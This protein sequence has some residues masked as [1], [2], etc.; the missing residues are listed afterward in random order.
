MMSKWLEAFRIG[1][2]IALETVSA[3]GKRR[4]DWNRLVR[5]RSIGCAYERATKV[6]F[7]TYYKPLKHYVS[8]FKYS[9]GAKNLCS[10]VRNL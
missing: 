3:L 5:E 9:L 6:G 1:R 2:E 4:R 8:S 10:R 7:H